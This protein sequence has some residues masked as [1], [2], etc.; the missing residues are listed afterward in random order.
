MARKR[1]AGPTLERR[2]GG[3]PVPP[4]SKMGNEGPDPIGTS[5]K[6]EAEAQILNCRYLRSG[7]DRVATEGRQMEH[8]D[9]TANL[10]IVLGDLTGWYARLVYRTIEP[11]PINLSA[12]GR[13][14]QLDLGGVRMVGAIVT[15]VDSPE[16]VVHFRSFMPTEPLTAADGWQPT[17]MPTGVNAELVELEV[18]ALAMDGA[19]IRG[20]ANTVWL[21][22]HYRPMERMQLPTSQPMDGPLVEVEARV[23]EA[24][25]NKFGDVPDDCLVVAIDDPATLDAA[26]WAPQTWVNLRAHE[27]TALHGMTQS[28]ESHAVGVFNSAFTTHVTVHDLMGM[29]MDALKLL[30]RDVRDALERALVAMPD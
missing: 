16:P 13:F 17:E 21:P 8:S 12:C 10:T 6:F 25:F 22:R 28:I 19:Q 30:P 1:K 14:A 24:M 23:L 15:P 29:D 20:W 18:L 26:G 9:M 7:P 11:R 27:W 2:L 5:E 3:S 4:S